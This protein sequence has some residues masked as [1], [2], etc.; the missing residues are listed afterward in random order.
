VRILK[1]LSATAVVLGSFLFVTCDGLAAKALSVSID[2]GVQDGSA[3]E[4]AE[5]P[6]EITK[7]TYPEGVV[8]LS[9]KVFLTATG[10]TS[11]YRWSV[12]SGALPAGVTLGAK[13]GLI[14]GTLT[15]AGTYS[16]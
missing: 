4:V 15:R 13:S 14:S 16:F 5:A 3:K 8:G 2:H 9:V 10:G 1:S 6:L 7:P 11:P 12:T